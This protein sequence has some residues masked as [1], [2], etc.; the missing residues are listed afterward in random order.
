MENSL[1][2]FDKS[3]GDYIKQEELALIH[4]KMK[5]HPL[6][7]TRSEFEDR[8]NLFIL[9]ERLKEFLHIKHDFIISQNNRT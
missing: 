9:M 6:P 3:L 7:Q 4:D 1:L 5:A 8:A 2:G